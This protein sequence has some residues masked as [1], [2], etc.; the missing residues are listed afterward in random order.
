MHEDVHLLSEIRRL[1]ELSIDENINFVLSLKGVDLEVVG[2]EDELLWAWPSPSTVSAVVA[3]TSMLITCS[4]VLILMTGLDDEH[5]KGFSRIISSDFT[6]MM[7]SSK[8]SKALL[9]HA[10][11]LIESFLE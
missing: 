9:N 7:Q 5:I 8:K 2:Y 10:I 3:R 1:V 6:P 11:E 4:S